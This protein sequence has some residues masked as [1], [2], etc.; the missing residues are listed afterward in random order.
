MKACSKRTKTTMLLLGLAT[1][2]IAACSSSEPARS[3]AEPITELNCGYR[4]ISPPNGAITSDYTNACGGTDTTSQNGSY[5]YANCTHGYIWEISQ[6]DSGSC[7]GR[8]VSA[9]VNPSPVPTNQS[10]CEA[11]EATFYVYGLDTVNDIQ[12]RVHLERAK[13]GVHV[14]QPLWVRL[15]RPAARRD[16]PRQLAGLARR[17]HGLGERHARRG[18]NL[19]LELPNLREAP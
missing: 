19:Q 2:A 13:Q 12:Y 5:G 18:A 15:H 17:R 3:T 6:I 1:V 10:D 4:N 16:G 11:T 8:K 7:G 9:V 14:E